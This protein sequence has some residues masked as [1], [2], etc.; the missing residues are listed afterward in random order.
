MDRM[1]PFFHVYGITS[2][3]KETWRRASDG[4]GSLAMEHLTE[5][6]TN[7]ESLCKEMAISDSG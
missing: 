7:K 3:R 2:K 4:V 6:E 1:T 5:L